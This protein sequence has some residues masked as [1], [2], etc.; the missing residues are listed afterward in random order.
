M[1]SRT[2][3]LLATLVTATL[4][5]LSCVPAPVGQTSLG[6]PVTATLDGSGGT[7][8]VSAGGHTMVLDVPA[9]ALAEA[10][11][12]SVEPV[13][14]PGLKGAPAVRFSPDGLRFALPATLIVSP[15][16]EGQVLIGLTFSAGSTVGELA[17][18]SPVEGGGV[19]I[20]IAHFSSAAVARREALRAR[21]SAEDQALVDAVGDQTE[22]AALGLGDRLRRVIEPAVARAGGSV[23]R[24][25][26]ASAVL[27]SWQAAVQA[28]DIGAEPTAV[29]GAETFTSA[30]TRLQ[31][32]LLTTAQTLTAAFHQ[33]LCSDPANEVHTVSD[34]L[35]LR[36]LT[37]SVVQLMGGEPPSQAQCAHY[38]IV[39]DGDPVL[40]AGDPNL[41][42]DVG[43]DL[44][45]TTG[46]RERT[47]HVR[48]SFGVTGAD[49]PGVIDSI[50]GT[51]EALRFSRPMTDPRPH[52]IVVTVD[53]DS[54]DAR[55][56]GLDV[57]PV[58]FIASEPMAAVATATPS[59]IGA[60][61]TAQICV[62]ATASGAAVSRFSARFTAD[63]GDVERQLFLTT[64][65]SLCAGYR[66]PSTLV[67]DRATIEVAVTIDGAPARTTATVLLTASPNRV[68]G[69]V[70]GATFT[71]A[72]EN[73]SYSVTGSYEVVIVNGTWTLVPTISSA[74]VTTS[75]GVERPTCENFRVFD[76][77][78]MG[79]PVRVS[80]DG[81][82][83]LL[84]TQSHFVT[85]NVA[86]T[87]VETFR[88]DGSNTCMV[89]TNTAPSEASVA[90]TLTLAPDLRSLEVTVAHNAMQLPASS[91][92]AR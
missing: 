76:T 51:A 88:D 69:G 74:S 60:D 62:T 31:A 39:V 43:F 25:A 48:F 70:T 59:T 32:S 79:A 80:D 37:S 44:V 65:G 68:F 5:A 47:G 38:E 46:Q 53:A 50:T 72:E 8:T 7:I 52:A 2:A 77:T 29:R 84:L 4:S 92:P 35:V 26:S 20:P 78:A 45:A 24:L 28:L 63:V 14:L 56:W 6:A 33:P 34:W 64:T 41:S 10:T 17:F 67:G 3:T 86:G 87:T 22:A 16:P 11:T 71:A 12:I 18:T 1:P 13:E 40:A 54:E 9:G 73:A 83:A 23:A 36:A 91:I 89:R 42:L 30:S 82:S 49:S 66:A 21:M 90:L 15:A 58:V 81:M 55:K 57:A 27:G 19:S 85:V 61:S 75:T